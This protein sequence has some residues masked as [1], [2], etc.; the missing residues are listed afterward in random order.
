MNCIPLKKTIAA[1]LPFCFLWLFLVCLSS[2]ADER[3]ENHQEYFALTET[4]DVAAS[5]FCPMSDAPD[6]TVPERAGFDFKFPDVASCLVFPVESTSF[7]T[8]R[9]TRCNKTPFADPPL[10]RLLVLRI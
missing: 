9:I 10:K 4:A 5:D 2:C 8:S 6:A 7:V 3:A 1:L